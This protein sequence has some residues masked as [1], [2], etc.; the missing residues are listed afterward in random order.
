MAKKPNK[1]S[2]RYPVGFQL[3]AVERMKNCEDIAKLAEELGVSRSP[4]AADKRRYCPDVFAAC[5][6][7]LA[8]ARS[9]LRGR[10]LKR[11]RERLER[12]LLIR[13]RR[14]S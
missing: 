4:S 10:F 7:L 5:D 11:R 2:K 13:R 3:D 8:R 1:R 12:V 14:A 6:L 9:R